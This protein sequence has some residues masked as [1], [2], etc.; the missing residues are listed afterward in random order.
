LE[1]SVV[2]MDARSTDDALRAVRDNGAPSSRG[3]AKSGLLKESFAV[4]RAI[5]NGLAATEVRTAILE[6]KLFQK[7]SVSTRLSIWMALRHRYF[8]ADPLVSRSLAAASLSGCDSLEFRSLAYGT[9]GDASGVPGVG[10]P[11][12]ILA[13]TPF[14]LRWISRKRL[15]LR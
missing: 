7:T 8:S 1:T 6:S 2:D 4:F 12:D 10:G 15:D 3:T 13:I 9:V 14:E 5:A 11:I